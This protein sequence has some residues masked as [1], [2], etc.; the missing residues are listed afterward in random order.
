MG[1]IQLANSSTSGNLALD[2]GTGQPA[3]SLS[4]D[5]YTVG[6]TSVNC[7]ATLFEVGEWAVRWVALATAGAGQSTASQSCYRGKWSVDAGTTW[8][9]CPGPSRAVW[10]AEHRALAIPAPL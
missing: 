10:K 7:G 4:N 8:R 3:K 9:N 6:L 5:C 1:G 2:S